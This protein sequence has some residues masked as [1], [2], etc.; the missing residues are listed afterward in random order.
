MLTCGTILKVT[1]NG[2]SA[3]GYGRVT[4]DRGMEMETLV[5]YNFPVKIVV[6]NPKP[7][8]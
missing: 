6:L 1:E 4:V 7:V 8:A 5:L 3:Q 2:L